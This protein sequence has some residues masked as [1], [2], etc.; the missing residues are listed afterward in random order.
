MKKLISL[1]FLATFCQGLFAQ[2]VDVIPQPAKVITQNGSFALK[3]ATKI[4][5][6]ISDK[7]GKE[8]AAQAQELLESASGIKP[9]VVPVSG[10]LIPGN[11]LVQLNNPLNAQTGTEGYKLKVEKDRIFLNANTTA[12]LYYG[13]QTLW[14]MLTAGDGKSIS[15]VDIT[16]YP[17]LSWRGMM[18]DVSRHYFPVEF[19]YK[20]IDYLALHKMNVFHWHLVDDQGWRIEIKKYPK[21]TEIG[22]W[23]ADREDLDWNSRKAPVKENEPK[24]GGFYTQDQI[25]SVV[26]YAR[27]K[28]ITVVPEIEMPAHAMAALAAYPELSCTGEYQP[29]PSGG[30]WPITH[31]FC[32]GK[33]ETFHFLEDVLTEV[34]ELFPS[35]FIHIG[36]DEATK[37]EWEKCALCQ[38]RMKDEHLADEHELQAYF[39]KRMEKFL[40]S[41]G[42]HLIGWDEILEGGVN[43]S[44]TIMSWRGTKPGI[45][46]VKAGH[47]VVMSPTSHCYFDYYQGDPSL[48]PKAFGG[49]ITLKKVYGFDPV[50][51][52]LTEDEGKHIIGV[53]ANLWTE[54]IPTPAHAEYMIMPR[55]SAL[56]EV[57][58]SPK[59]LKDWG[60]FSKRMETQ[61]KRF[62]KIGANYATSAFQVTA[63]PELNPENRSIEVTLS[64]E[65]WQPE[66]YYTVDGS[67]PDAGSTKYTS[68]FEIQKTT[69]VK[70][71]VVKDGKTMSKP[72]SSTFFMHKAI[73]C[74]V[75]MKFPNSRYYN[76]SGEFALVDGIKGST[77]HADGNWKGFNG[78]DLVA[79]IDLGKETSFS[80][81]TIGVLQ[82]VGAWIFSPTEVTVETSAD[83]VNFKKA[84]SVKNKVNTN[85][86]ERQI[87]DITVKK[88]ASARY[89]RVTVKNLGTCPQG[90]AG[91]GK[92]AW[93]FVDEISVE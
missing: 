60:S 25:K 23:R 77:N 74:P 46:A 70:A 33:E 47:D 88:K 21:L 53:Q 31:I 50:P 57:A 82:N 64:T 12:G 38:K 6:N 4:L 86:G 63:S 37:T 87:K 65:A 2:T 24:Y 35:T 32:A 27:K 17:R 73:A 66:I 56:A 72:M 90:H 9:E 42:R 80:K 10:P 30:V 59:E 69:V 45:E 51:E 91:E 83:C 3:P 1:L 48:E 68:P 71:V 89:L 7:D 40:N 67:D 52:E 39:I 22:A 13:M 76:A 79:T 85:D 15:C 8:F 62:E 18:L 44:A 41:Y 28:Y 5:F 16:D 14:Q 29:V 20:Y 49:H 54:Q 11:I 43:P 55:M 93:L 26:E 81:V 34:M 78:N 75:T 61:Y 58:W 36:G 19:I 84:A 92:P